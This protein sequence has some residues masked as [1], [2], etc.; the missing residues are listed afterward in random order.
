MRY[1]ANMRLVNVR[2]AAGDQFYTLTPAS[3]TYLRVD[4][5]KS[6]VPFARFLIKVEM[7]APFLALDACVVAGDEDSD[8]PAIERLGGKSFYDMVALDPEAFHV[9]MRAMVT[10]TAEAVAEGSR[11]VFEGVTTVVDVG[12]GDGMMAATIARAFPAIKCVVL[13]LAHVVERAPERVGVEFVAGDMFVSLPRADAL[14][15]TRV[16]HN[17]S[18]DKVT[19]ILRR[20]M[21][22]I[23]EDKGKVIIIDMVIDD[24]KEDPDV[25][26]IKLSRDIIMMAYHGGKERTKEEWRSLLAK[27]LDVARHL[28]ASAAY[29]ADLAVSNSFYHR[30]PP[31]LPAAY[32]AD[33][34]VAGLLPRRPRC[35]GLLPPLF[36]P[37][38][39]L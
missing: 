10:R 12:G 31:T 8:V 21:E 16:L 39:A 5:E 27:S 6:F 37:L 38:K 11:A 30:P 15:F 17:W 2:E 13:E 7:I 29:L 34:A 28:T 23:D 20:C 35:V 22:A 3:S 25:H 19:E 18:D 26:Q 1:L 33:L 24:S 36:L 4:S 32:L 14:L 9:T